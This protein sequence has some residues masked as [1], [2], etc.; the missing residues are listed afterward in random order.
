MKLLV[1]LALTWVVTRGAMEP[2]RTPGSFWVTTEPVPGRFTNGEVMSTT[3]VRLPYRLDVRWRR[4]GPEGG[5]SLHV[6]IAGGI[7]L[8]QSGQLALYAY[9]EAALVAR[10]WTAVPTLATHAEHAIGVEQDL[11]EVRVFVDGAVVLRQ[12]LV[13]GRATTKVGVGLK[14]AGGYRSSLYVGAIAVAELPPH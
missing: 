8:V 9:D 4:I 6:I 11:Q 14:G 2:G 7:V 1:A 3:A 10:G 12:P 5:R 13:A